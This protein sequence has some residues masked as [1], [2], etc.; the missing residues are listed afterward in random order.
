MSLL[1][2][3]SPDRLWEQPYPLEEMFSLAVHEKNVSETGFCFLKEGNENS[4]NAKDISDNKK[5]QRI[6]I[7]RSN[8]LSS[9]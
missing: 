2:L 4:G 8:I 9:S 7:F 5:V 6:V 1:T 3:P